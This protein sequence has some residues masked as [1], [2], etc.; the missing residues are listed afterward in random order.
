MTL[1]THAV[2]G[3]FV[4]A[5]ASQN[6]ALAASAGFLSHFI[7]DSIPHWDYKLGSTSE[8]K[9]KPMETDM[10]ISGKQFYIDLFKIGCDVA[11]GL[12]LTYLFFSH[13][14]STVLLA[15]LIGAC[16]AIAPDPL[17][18]VY[19]KFR[20]EP[21][22]SLQ[23]FHLFMHADTRLNDKPLIGITSQIIIMCIVYVGIIYLIPM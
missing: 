7:M 3:A 15:A 22:I 4:G 9:S 13:A 2:V 14:S 20:R 10:K 17:Q 23:K 6:L 19:W 16:C 5:V 1:S 12:S 11:L 8:D 18:F 21:L